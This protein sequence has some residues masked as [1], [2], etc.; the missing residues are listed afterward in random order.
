[1]LLIKRIPNHIDL[2]G[3]E[4]ALAHRVQGGINIIR[5]FNHS[6]ALNGAVVINQ[7]GI[8]VYPNPYAAAF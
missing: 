8:T 2:S 3:A 7:K 4:A 5:A 6:I 1:M